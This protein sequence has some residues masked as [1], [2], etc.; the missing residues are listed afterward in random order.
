MPGPLLSPREGAKNGSIGHVFIKFASTT[1]K[2]HIKAAGLFQSN[3]SVFLVLVLG[4]VPGVFC[5]C[6]SG[7]EVGGGDIF[8]LG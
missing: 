7:V 4:V 1:F 5:L 6:F 8:S 3:C 2:Q